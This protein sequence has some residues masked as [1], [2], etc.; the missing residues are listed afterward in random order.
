MAK[1]ETALTAPASSEALAL[2]TQEFPVDNGFTRV[3]LPRLGLISQDVTEEVRNPTTK[4]KEIKVITEAGTFFI[5]T[6]TDEVDENGKK[7]WSKNELGDEIEGIILF[8]RKQLRHY[9]NATG[10]FTNSPVYDNDDEVMPLWKNRAEIG[11]GTEKELQALPQFRVEKN[12]KVQSALE[13]TRILYVLFET[14][15][16]EGEPERKIYQ[17]NLRGSSMFSYLTYKRK[18]S[19]PTVLTKFTSSTQENGDVTWNR[20]EFEAVRPITN[21][22]AVEVIGHVKD[23]KQGIAMQKGYFDAE[24]KTNK[25]FEEV[26]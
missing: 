9:D 21:A 16:E 14:E 25:E 17:M 8:Q 15:N 5:D 6:E 12:G 24:A 3:M 19:P 2:L 4:K 22:E 13:V 23:L 10:E 20:M 11:R 1:K 7:V 26:G 18:T